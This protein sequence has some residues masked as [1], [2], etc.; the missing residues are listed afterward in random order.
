MPRDFIQRAARGPAVVIATRVD[1]AA[2]HPHTVRDPVYVVA[3]R[4]TAIRPAREATIRASAVFRT[5]PRRRHDPS[6]AGRGATTAAPD[7]SHRPGAG[8]AVPGAC[9]YEQSRQSHR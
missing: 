4:H 7:A 5:V 6:F 3:L 2:L 9:R 1:E 8:H